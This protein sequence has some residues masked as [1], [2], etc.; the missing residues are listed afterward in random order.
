MV[1]RVLPS[2]FCRS[3]EPMSVN[4]LY[5]TKK[6]NINMVIGIIPLIPKFYQHWILSFLHVKIL[7]NAS[8]VGL[9]QNALTVECLFA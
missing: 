5:K 2:L 1:A 4:T 6:P 9:E 7:V 8:T 3:D